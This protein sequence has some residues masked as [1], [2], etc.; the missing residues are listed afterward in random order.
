MPTR[1]TTDELKRELDAALVPL[2]D[3][4][5]RLART[6]VR[7]LVDGE[8]VETQRVADALGRPTA[9][10]AEALE[11]LPWVYRDKDGRVVGA[12]GMSVANLAQSPHRLR[13]DDREVYAWCAQDTLFLPLVL[14]EP[15]AVESR[16][17]TTGD[18]I[19]LKVHPEGLGDLSPAS[20]TLSFLRIGEGAAARDA[21]TSFCHFIHFF[22][23]ED[24]AQEW[25]AEHQG[26]FVLPLDE[27]F[28]LARFWAQR[29]F[30]VGEEPAADE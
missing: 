6:L 24:A 14:G 3:A 19:S 9:E 29:A 28:E 17:P 10:A 20:A 5:R 11:R 15:A 18:R 4:D 25:I 30:G 1:T 2:T 12:W 23:S 13:V 16:C 27:A 21:I 22:A 8:P 7:L 26:T